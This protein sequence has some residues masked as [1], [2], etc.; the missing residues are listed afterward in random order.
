M[1][2]QVRKWLIRLTATVLLVS[3]LLLLLILNPILTYAHRTTAGRFTVYHTRP[4]DRHF[5]SCLKDAGELLRASEFYREGIRLDIC[6]NDG[7][8]YPDLVHALRGDAFAWGFYD[9]V[10]LH[11][12]VDADAN[13]LELR[14][15]RWNLSQLLAHEMTHCLQFDQLGWRHS[16]PLAG[17]PAWKWEG[18]AEYVARQGPDQK[19]LYRNIKRFVETPETQWSVAFED[20]TIAPRDYYQSWLLVQYCM[21]V[22][23]MKYIDLLHDSSDEQLLHNAMMAW[24]ADHSK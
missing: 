4:L 2:K 3:V 24:Y 6:L 21:D 11:G 18:Y 5:L 12:T 17:I 7:S 15:Y 1:R 9:K 14:G 13:V 19:D 10:V 16:N 20:S 22:K 23:C 8:R